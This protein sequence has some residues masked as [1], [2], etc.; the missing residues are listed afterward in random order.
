MKLLKLI[1]IAQFLFLLGC[2]GVSMIK[3]GFRSDL[4]TENFVATLENVKVNYRQGDSPLAL[5]MLNSMQEA[6][7][8]VSEK[9]M[10]R[11]LIGVILFSNANFEQAIFN[12][13]LAL[14]I[15]ITV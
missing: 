3:S 11:N 7:L 10:R 15:Y 5:K 6:E 13:N 12:F 9:A 1:F 4:Y 8:L 14:L 2:G